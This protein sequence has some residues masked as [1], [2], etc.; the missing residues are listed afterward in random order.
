MAFEVIRHLIGLDRTEHLKRTAVTLFILSFF[1]GHV[2]PAVFLLLLILTPLYPIVVLYLAWVFVFD[3]KSPKSGFFW[4]WIR[5]SNYVRHARVFDYLRDF[6]PVRLVKTTDL[7][8][9]KNYIFAYHPHGVFAVGCFANF[10]TEATG[11]SQT[12]PGVTVWCMTFPFVFAAPLVREFLMLL[13]VRSVCESGCRHILSLGTGH[14]IAIV[15][16]GTKDMLEARPG[17]AKIAIR[18]RKGFV[19]IALQSG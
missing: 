16:G 15:P 17:S 12:F 10:A 13:G 4:P 8:P 19:R 5:R 3:W 9:K 6:F 7:D 14:S 1:C 11:F 18:K 2:I